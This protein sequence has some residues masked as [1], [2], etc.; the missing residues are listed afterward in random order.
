MSVQKKTLDD[1]ISEI[2]NLFKQT[3]FNPFERMVNQSNR[4]AV[5]NDS[6]HAQGSMDA[7]C[8]KLEFGVNAELCKY[9]SPQLKSVEVNAEIDQT[10]NGSVTVNLAMGDEAAVKAFTA[11]NV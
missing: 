4:L 9:I 5:R 10:I 7:D 11:D 1:R 3:G 2:T 8:E 6:L